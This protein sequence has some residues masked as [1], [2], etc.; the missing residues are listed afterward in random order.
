MRFGANRAGRSASGNAANHDHAYSQSPIP[1]SWDE[2]KDYKRQVRDAA[3]LEVERRF[4]RMRSNGRA[5]MSAVRR[6]NVGM[7]RTQFSRSDGAV[8]IDGDE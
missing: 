5:A 8:W 2:F 7:Q 4:L 3:V 6:R 1:R